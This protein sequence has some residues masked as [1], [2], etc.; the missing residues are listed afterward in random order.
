MTVH[1]YDGIAVI[2][3][4]LESDQLGR[5]PRKIFLDMMAV[6]PTDVAVW[7]WDG[8]G[9]K[10]WRQAIY[11]A[12]KAKRVPQPDSVWATIKM[13]RNVL[14]YTKALQVT[15]PEFE[16]DDLI[17]HYAQQANAASHV[18]IHSVDKDLSAL[19]V[20]PYVTASFGLVLAAQALETIRNPEC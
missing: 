6:K 12:Y 13:M 20:N 5:A 16:A 10:Q 3:R 4:D 17:A 19:M 11:P 7:C 14:R 9:A 8:Q 1:L 2:R 15:A 18:K